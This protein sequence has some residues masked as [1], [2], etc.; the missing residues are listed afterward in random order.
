MIY[1]SKIDRNLLDLAIKDA[2]ISAKEHKMH[3]KSLNDNNR[4]GFTYHTHFMKIPAHITIKD[5][6]QKIAYE[7]AVTNSLFLSTWRWYGVEVC[8]WTKLT[9]LKHFCQ[10]KR[11]IRKFRMY[12]CDKEGL[13]KV[14]Y[15]DDEKYEK[16]LE[17][18]AEYFYQKQ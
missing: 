12:Q 3:R 14:E 13:S 4:I 11:Y 1:I 10:G 8:P 18:L 17:P 6:G 2:L 15:V 7:N 5:W 9:A 16:W